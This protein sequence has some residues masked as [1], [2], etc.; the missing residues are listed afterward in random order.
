M[1][2]GKAETSRSNTDPQLLLHKLQIHQIELEMQNDELQRLHA[3]AEEAYRQ[4]TDLYDFAPVGYFTLTRDGMIQEVNLAGANLLGTER[5][6]LVDRRLGLFVSSESR[7]AFETFF[8]K[9]LSHVG[10]ETCDLAFLKKGNEIFWVRIEA[11]C[12]D[13]GQTSRAVLLDITERKQVEDELM[14]LSIHDS[15]TGLYNRSFFMEEMGR[16]ER[17]REFPI[18]I[19]M[20]DVDGLKET[21]DQ[22]GHDAGDI[23]LKR[24]SL[25]LTTAFRAGD[26]VA[27]IGGDEFAVL[28]PATDAKTAQVSVQRVWQIIREDNASHSGTPVHISL[29]V[30]T[31]KK[32]SLLSD[33]LKEADANM[34][35]EKRKYNNP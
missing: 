12:F 11:T 14:R 29:G 32:K 33:V 18:S 13:D 23:L 4:Y 1:V 9:L 17:G 6:K 20:A 22:M 35:R 15:M 25:A 16:L 19:V 5:D 7:A 31:A 10:K 8:E 21:N 26:V 24:A 30:S 3:E 28:L 27:R 34:Y 2:K